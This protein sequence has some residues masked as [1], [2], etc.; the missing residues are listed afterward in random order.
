MTEKREIRILV[1]G[2]GT[3]GHVSPALAVI[4]KLREQST[5]ADWQP[6]FRYL[7]SELGIEKTLAQ[8]AG[9]EFVGVQSGKLRRSRRLTGLLSRKNLTDAF[10]VPVGIAQAMREVG[11]FRP[12]V[13]F[14]T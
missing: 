3:G 6:V 7:G 13:V 10:R 14:A 11:R 12:D 2:G 8:E 4:Q 5:G 1:T 9:V